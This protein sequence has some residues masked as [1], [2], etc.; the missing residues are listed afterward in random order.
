MLTPS[1]VRLE[2]SP[3]GHFTDEA[4]QSILNRD[5]PRVNFTYRDTEGSWKSARIIFSSIMIKKN[6]PLRDFP[7]SPSRW[8]RRRFRVEPDAVALR[9]KVPTLKG[10]TRTLDTVD[11]ACELDEGIMSVFQGVACVDDSKSLLL[12]EDGMGISQKRSGKGHLSL[13]LTASVTG[14]R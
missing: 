2:Y 11:G 3:E 7:V 9:E 8:R 10:T 4:T 14:R 6:F 12:G 5:F 13:L 1:M